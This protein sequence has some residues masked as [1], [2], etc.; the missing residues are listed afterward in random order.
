[1]RVYGNK[2]ISNWCLT[3]EFPFTVTI[4]WGFLFSSALRPLR[5]FPHSGEINPMTGKANGALPGP[6]CPCTER[7]SSHQGAT[8]HPCVAMGMVAPAALPLLGRGC[9]CPCPV[10]RGSSSVRMWSYE[11]TGLIPSWQLPLIQSICLISQALLISCFL[12]F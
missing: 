8:P 2:A 9:S 6:C 4:P 5:E 12:L 10:P 7:Q 1:M 11:S 3:G